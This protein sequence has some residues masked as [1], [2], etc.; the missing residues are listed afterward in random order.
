MDKDGNINIYKEQL[1]V[2]CFKWIYSIDYDVMFSLIM[3]LKSVWILI[4]I[5]AYFD[6]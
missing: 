3:M 4:S 5:A 6:Y 2:K 1:V